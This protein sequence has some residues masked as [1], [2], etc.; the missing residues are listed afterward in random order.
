MTMEKINKNQEE[1]IQKMTEKI[2]ENGGEIFLKKS[3]GPNLK[4]ENGG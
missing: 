3:S 2:K 4:I 1:K